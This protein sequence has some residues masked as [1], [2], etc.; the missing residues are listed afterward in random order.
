MSLETT[1]CTPASARSSVLVAPGDAEYRAPAGK[2]A[3]WQAEVGNSSRR[4]HDYLLLEQTCL[5]DRRYRE[6]TPVARGAGTAAPDPGQVFPAS[7]GEG[8]TFLTKATPLR[9][10]ADGRARWAA[11]SP[12][13][14]TAARLSLAAVWAIAGFSKVTDP[15]A[16]VRAVRAYQIL[17]E[18]AVHLVGYA[19]PFVELGLAVLLVLGIGTRACAVASALLLLLF[20]AAVASAGLRGLAIDCGCFGG[21]GA[22][23]PG[24]T[25]YLAELARDAGFLALA[26]WLLAAPGSRLALDLAGPVPEPATTPH[27]PDHQ[28]T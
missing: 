4:P 28:E 8:M 16:T 13:I 24:A 27:R 20:M 1:A 11:A 17:P 25:Q 2:L 9:A 14:S 18:S 12:W 21:G 23:A 5:L 3:G 15:A 10:P 19:L 7:E 22:V 26:G 6:Q